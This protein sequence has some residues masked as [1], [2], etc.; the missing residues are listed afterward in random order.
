MLVVVLLLVVVMWSNVC[1]LDPTMALVLFLSLVF[2][3]NQLEA[4][5][6]RPTACIHKLLQSLAVDARTS[7]GTYVCMRS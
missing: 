7:P 6:P 2:V 5:H 4:P 1:P 3:T